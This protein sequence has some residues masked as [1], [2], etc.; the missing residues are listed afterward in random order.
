MK[1][2]LSAFQRWCSPPKEDKSSLPL[3]QPSIDYSENAEVS[4]QTRAVA[5][6]DILGWG[7]AVEDSA[8]S[9]ELRRKLLNA[10]WAL[11][12]LSKTD[13]EDDTPASPSL[14]QV[15]QFSDSVVISIPYSGHFDL[16]RLVRQ[17]TSYQHAMFK[18]GLPLRGGITVG[19]LYH[20]NSY[21]FGP[22]LNE[23]YLL[24]SKMAHHPRVIIAHS[25]KSEI[26]QAAASMPKGW[27]FVELDDDDF[28]STD[29]LGMYA[30]SEWASGEVD[31][32]INRWLS[33]YKDDARTYQ[34]YVWLKSRWEKTS[35]QKSLRPESNFSRD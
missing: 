13:A 2:I 26:E 1:K 5:F 15:T 28:Y 34:K 3:S 32:K 4:Y 14:D 33:K 9:S 17:I 31:K 10:V 16:L 8:I 35:L 24:E 29:F 18:V 11:G 21:V 30:K 25:L 20:S 27:P 22:A 7:R 12:A 19:Q 23:A 6:I